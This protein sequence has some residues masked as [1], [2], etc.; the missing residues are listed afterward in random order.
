MKTSPEL[1]K[2]ADEA[3]KKYFQSKEVQKRLVRAKKQHI[4]FGIKLMRLGLEAKEKVPNAS[5]EDIERWIQEGIVRE[6]PF[7][8]KRRGVK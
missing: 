7:F 5:K 8:Q 2:M 3:A 4:E 6:F 1:E